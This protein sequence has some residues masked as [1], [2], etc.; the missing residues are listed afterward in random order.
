MVVTAF[1]TLSHEEPAH[2][3]TTGPSLTNWGGAEYRGVSTGG[4]WTHSESENHINYLEMLAFFLGLET[5]A[6]NISNSHIRLLCDNTTTVNVI[7]HV[8][9]SH[10]DSRKRM[11]KQIW[12]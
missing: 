3:I 1:Q 9:T 8:G 10:S 11:V 12:E 5:F 7:N 2:Q 4:I 6:K